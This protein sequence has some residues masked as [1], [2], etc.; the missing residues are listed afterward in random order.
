MCVL[1]ALCILPPDI[2]RIKARVAGHFHFSLEQIES[3]GREQHLV[4]ARHVSMYLARKLTLASFPRLA[5]CYERRN[6]TSVIHA[7]E[8][9]RRRVNHDS[10]FR[11]SILELERK[12]L[13]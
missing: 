9:I 11:S 7:C 12:V 8:A 13:E 6:H 1:R 4:L 10:S 5:E 3:R 2:E